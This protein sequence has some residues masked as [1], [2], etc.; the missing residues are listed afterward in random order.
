MLVTFPNQK[1]LKKEFPPSYS[2]HISKVWYP[3]WPKFASLKKKRRK[4]TL[5]KFPNR[6]KEPSPF[7]FYLHTIHPIHS[8]PKCII[9]EA[10]V[11]VPKEKKRKRM[12]VIFPIFKKNPPLPISILTIR[13]IP[14]TI[15][16]KS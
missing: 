4:G 7:S 9:Q 13:H 6:K 12:L 8:I 16:P 1:E 5:V 15:I 10:E 2:T 3:K 14:K 11:H